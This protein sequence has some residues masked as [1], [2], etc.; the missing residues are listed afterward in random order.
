MKSNEIFS[1]SV[2]GLGYIGLPTSALLASNGYKVHGIDLNKS[3]VKVINQGKVH[4]VEPDLDHFVSTAVSSGHLTAFCEVQPADVY[5]ICVPTPF[6]FDSGAPVADV[7]YIKQ[8][9]CNIAPHIKPG[10]IIILEST[11]PV[12]TTQLVS[13]VLQKCGVD[14]A[15]IYLAY[16]PERVLPGK[17]MKELISNDRVVGGINLESTK[18]VAEFYRTFVEGEILET[19]AETAEMCKL[20]ENSFRDVNIA[21][22]NELSMICDKNGVDV[23]D[24][25]NLANHHPRVNI[26]QP[27][28]GVGGHCIAVDPWFLVAGDPENTKIIKI[29]REV[30]DSKPK[31]VVDQIIKN[32]SRL[33]NSSAKILC[34]GLAFKP[35]I[36]DL[37]ESPAL[38]VVRSL[39]Q[40]GHE[41]AAVEPNIDCHSDL[42][43]TT[44]DQLD[45]F[46]I[47]A[48]LVKHKEFDNPQIKNYLQKKNVMDFCG[49]FSN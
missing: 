8:A 35:D 43:I 19:T 3:I 31:W 46:D 41:V 25:I 17:I 11:S 5:I 24:L 2:I 44:L 15:S 1:I 38:E 49:L 39:I 33:N 21:F 13:D 40:L 14:I 36:D 20:T 18:K 28:T 29:A 10:D 9:S 7:S 34:L 26:L 42:E 48:V 23:H 6:K 27:G 32:K 47:I 4:I 22:A 45:D 16:C 37:R 12:G 30:N